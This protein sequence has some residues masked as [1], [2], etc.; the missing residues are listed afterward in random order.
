M[1]LSPYAWSDGTGASGFLVPYELETSR[2]LARVR[3]L[4][5]GDVFANPLTVAHE[6]P[7]AGDRVYF[8]G[9]S[10]KNR[11][12]AMA[13]DVIEA[14]VTRVIALHVLFTPSGKPG[15]SG[16]CVVNEWG[17]VVGINEGGYE[18]DDKEQAGLAV[19]VWG[20][21]AKMPE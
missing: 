12:D 2:D 5:E 6:A 9:Y 4:R 10:W 3:P 20:V 18:T 7:K 14:R 11:K 19:G 21:L 8:L 1:P 16:S 15:S 17:E 13:D